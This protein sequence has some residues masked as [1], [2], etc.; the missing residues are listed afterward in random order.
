MLTERIEIQIE[1]VVKDAVEDIALMGGY[2]ISQ[3][4]N[5]LLIAGI[6][7][8][9]TESEKKTIL[10]EMKNGAFLRR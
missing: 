1:E 8:K 4:C 2:S 6:R 3:V 9:F 5:H 7:S 10:E